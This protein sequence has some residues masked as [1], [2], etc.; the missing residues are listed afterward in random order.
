MIPDVEVHHLES[1]KPL[2]F[3]NISIA[4][5]GPVRGSLKT[6]VKL[7][8]STIVVHVRFKRQIFRQIYSPMIHR[9]HSM[10][11]QVGSRRRMA[12]I[13]VLIG[14]A[15]TTKVNSRSFVRFDAEVDYKERHRFL[16]FEL[17]LNIHA[18]E[19]IY[20]TQFGHISRPTHKNTTWVSFLQPSWALS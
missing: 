17:P 11:S 12:F 8:K 9:Y 7:G 14:C 18:Q 4:E 16:K 19:A 13:A 2:Q 3:A 5:T 10:L 6:E 15:A 1:R 20:E